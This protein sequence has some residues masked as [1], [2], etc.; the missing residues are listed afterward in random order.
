MRYDHFHLKMLYAISLYVPL[1]RKWTASECSPN[2]FF[3]WHSYSPL[4]PSLA[5]L[6]ESVVSRSPLTIWIRP[7]ALESR[8]EPLRC[9]SHWTSSLFSLPNNNVHLKSTR[10]PSLTV[11]DAFSGLNRYG[12]TFVFL[13]SLV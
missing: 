6:M 9:H 4:S 11:C 5:L 13:F 2:L 12:A 3:T 1:T 8:R 10:L 7:S